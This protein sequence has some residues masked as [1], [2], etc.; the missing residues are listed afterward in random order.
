MADL[1]F[2]WAATQANQEDADG[3]WQI[4]E[5]DYGF[6]VGLVSEPRRK[7]FYLARVGDNLLG[8]GYNINDLGAERAIWLKHAIDDYSKTERNGEP[9]PKP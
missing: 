2:R 1:D 7:A 6:T 8:P 4:H 9:E 5:S 3:N